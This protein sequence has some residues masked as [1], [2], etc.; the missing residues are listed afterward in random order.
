MDLSLSQYTDLWGFFLF[1]HGW[2]WVFWGVIVVAGWDPFATPGVVFLVLGGIGPMLGGILMSGVVGGRRELRDLG[3]RIFDPRLVPLRWWLVVFGFVPAVTA[4]AAL[5]ASQLGLTAQPVDFGEASEVFARPTA[6]LV[7]VG[8][9]LILGP[10][11]EEIGWRGFLLDRLQLRWSALTASLLVGIA[12][13]TW[14]APLFA[15]TGYYAAVG[16]TPDLFLFVTGIVVTS[17]LYTWI[18]NNAGRSVLAAILFHFMQNFVGQVFE[19]A[20]E[21][22]LIQ[23]ML[24]IIA[25]GVVLQIWGPRHLRRK[26]ARPQPVTGLSQRE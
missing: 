18:H 10:V 6:L 22:R 21:T 1:S 24:F 26:N 19:P 25:A 3:Q 23:A 15:M 2:T 11:P 16:G 12:W 9:I 20:P 14:H 5:V 17:V 7:T 4:L 8:F 13:L